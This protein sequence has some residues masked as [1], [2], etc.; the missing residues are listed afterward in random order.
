MV[1]I[2]DLP[3]VSKNKLKKISFL[4]TKKGRR[5]EGKFI[6][7][8]LRL[9]KEGLESNYKCETILVTK[10]FVNKQPEFTDVIE[11]LTE[12]VS[13][14]EEKDFGKITDTKNPQGIAAIFHIRENIGEIKLKDK[15]IIA[16]E[17]ITDPGNLGTI[18]RNCAWFG[19]DEVLISNNSADVYNPKVLRASMGAIFHLNIFRS[20]KFYDVLEH[21]KN[22]GYKLF[23]AD[24]IG[25]NIF[26]FTPPEKMIIAF[27]NEAFGPSTE[28][29]AI[30]E[31]SLTIPKAGRIESLNVASASAVIMAELINR[32]VAKNR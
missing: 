15:L 5:E 20:K 14:I 21:S 12:K 1:K 7:E 19:I 27:S 8:G 28:L 3:T 2:S 29:K 24:L 4:K 30:S 13:L 9:V 32:N 17:N 6:A 26:D 10:E 18:L 23:Y 16:L 25:E 31:N 22:K 11:I